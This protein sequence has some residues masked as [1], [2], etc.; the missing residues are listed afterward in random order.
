MTRNLSTTSGI[1]SRKRSTSSS[2]ED[3]PRVTRS[4]PCA[5]SAGIPIPSKTC[6]GSSDD[7][8]HADPL[9]QEKPSASRSKRMD[10]PSMN[11]KETLTLLGETFRRMSVEFRVRYALNDA[12][13]Q[14]IAQTCLA[15]C[16]AFKG[17]NSK[18]ESFAK[19]TA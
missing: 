8:V 4:E 14:T 15:F 16:L 13:D 19:P 2:V 11:S 5:I 18:F 3:R 12:V 7:D 10:S 1:T 6:D 9:E 17:F